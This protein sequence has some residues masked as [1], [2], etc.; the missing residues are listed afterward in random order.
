MSRRDRRQQ[1]D[2]SAQPLTVAAA[3]LP[4]LIAEQS[5]R[6]FRALRRIQAAPMGEWL[7]GDAVP[8]AIA[9]IL[10]AEGFTLGNELEEV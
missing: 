6:R 7:A 1:P 5:E 2:T 9:E 10:L 3:S 4:V 8:G